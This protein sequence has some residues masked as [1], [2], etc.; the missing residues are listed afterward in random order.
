MQSNHHS[1]LSCLGQADVHL[2]CLVSTIISYPKQS[3]GY[4]RFKRSQLPSELINDLVIEAYQILLFYLAPWR[5]WGLGYPGIGGA[6]LLLVLNSDPV[7]DISTVKL[8]NQSES[9][10]DQSVSSCP[11]E[12]LPW[13]TC[14]SELPGEPKGFFFLI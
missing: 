14:P 3:I 2:R 12:A 6:S 13:P 5:K 7:C 1:N 8:K 9:Q 10:F 11:P 4:I